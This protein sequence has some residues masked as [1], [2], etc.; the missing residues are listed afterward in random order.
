[1]RL[2]INCVVISIFADNSFVIL[3]QKQ[4]EPRDSKL[5]KCNK[6]KIAAF[7]IFNKKKLAV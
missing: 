1:M 6:K 3:Y 2:L 7:K 5:S 4:N